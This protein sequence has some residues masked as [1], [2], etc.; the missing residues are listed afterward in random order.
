VRG[1][2]SVYRGLEGNQLQFRADILKNVRGGR[3]GRRGTRRP[4]GC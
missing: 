1:G 2:G 4:T 3:R